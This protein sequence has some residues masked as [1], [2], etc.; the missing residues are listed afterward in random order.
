MAATVR[1]LGWARSGIVE[2]GTVVASARRTRDIG[3]ILALSA[4]ALAGCSASVDP[5][6][7][8]GADPFSAPIVPGASAVIPAGAAQSGTPIVAPRRGTGTVTVGVPVGRSFSD[9]LVRDFLRATGFSLIQVELADTD[10]AQARA[11]ETAVD[12]VMGLDATD[13]VAGTSGGALAGSAPED[14]R[15]AEGTAL[16]GAAGAVAYGR[17]DV[18]VLADA[19]W[20]AANGLALPTSLA[21]LAS[22]DY[23]ALLEIPDPGTTTAGRAFVQAT[24][25]QQGEGAAAWWGAL[26][27]AG[28]AVDREADALGR[29]T[30]W[31]SASA[32]FS[33]VAGLASATA[34]EG[35]R[36]L[37]VGP[38]S[39]AATTLNNTA[40]ESASAPIGSTCL[41]RTLYAAR[42]AAPANPD[43]AESLL[44]YLLT[45]R[46]QQALAQQ[47]LATPLAASVAEDTP[48][49]WFAAPSPD[50]LTLSDEQLPRAA[51][52]VASFQQVLSAR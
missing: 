24:A 16:A 31:T 2:E 33:T 23:A 20:F 45:P 1:R 3:V 26:L 38:A 42:V 37:L 44:A 35:T 25:A 10:L 27:G 8:P 7:D 29:W 17:D 14:A 6:A 28:A 36:P 32:G 22:P 21:D 39:W 47:S 46:A 4:A 5:S 18:C 48:L 51:D 34:G 49:G 13:A 41:A 40:T 12:V 43:G 11:G 19:Q 9:E 15:T 30:A 52:E 50:A